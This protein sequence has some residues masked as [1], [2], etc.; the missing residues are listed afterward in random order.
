MSYQ[1]VIRAA[2]NRLLTNHTIG[3]KIS[4]VQDSVNGATIYSERQTPITNANGLV[5]LEIGN[6]LVISGTFAGIKWSGG[7]YYIKTETDTAGGTSYSI[8]GTSQLLSVPYSYFSNE[9]GKIE[10]DSIHYVGEFFGG[11]LVYYIYDGGL[12]GLII[13]L[14]DVHSSCQWSNIFNLLIGSSAQS[15][16]NGLGNTNAIIAQAGFVSGAAKYCHDYNAGGFT[17]WYLPSIVEVILMF[18]AQYTIDK[19]LD[20]D[21]NP[22]TK[23]L[24]KGNYWSSTEYDASSV[25]DI[26]IFM[27]ATQILAKNTF[28]FV[29]A[30]RSF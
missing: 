18:N 14:A 19:I 25:D 10:N 27:G 29:R 5:S 12:H 4:I 20:S 24:S 28:A 3:M 23:S 16:W 26:I 7:K 21:N 13:S 8:S 11:G 17:D 1:A 30:V 15:I 22:S 2:N 6:G 9:A